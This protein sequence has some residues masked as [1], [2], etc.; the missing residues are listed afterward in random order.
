[1]RKPLALILTVCVG[2]LAVGC[3]PE[4]KPEPTKVPQGDL[5]APAKSTTASPP[6]TT[7]PAKK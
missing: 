4:K 6:S 7:P 1:M 2:A 5:G 3:E